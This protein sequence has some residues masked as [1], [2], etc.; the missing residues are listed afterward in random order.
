MELKGKNVLV[1]G[2][3]VSGVAAAELLK[4]TGAVVV[5]LDGNQKLDVETL[6]KEHPVF[7][8]AKIFLGDLPDE[9][10]GQIDLYGLS[11]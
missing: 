3:G 2:S 9:A 11:N 8:D 10:A 7:A 1:A 5:L 4:K 6:R